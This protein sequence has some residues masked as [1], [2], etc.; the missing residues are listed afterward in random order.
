MF[1]T[2]VLYTGRPNSSM[3]QSLRDL[4]N[5]RADFQSTPHDPH[6]VAGEA[7]LL[8]H[9]VPR[10]SDLSPLGLLWSELEGRPKQPLSSNVLSVNE[11]RNPKPTTPKDIPPVNMRQ[12][13]LSRMNEVSSVRDEWPANFGRLDNMNDANISGRIHQVEAEHHLNFDGHLLLQQIRREQQQQRQ[14]QLMAHNN[15]EFSG[16]FPGQVFDP[17][18][19]HRQPMNQQIPDVEHLLRIQFEL[20]QQQQRQLQQEQHQR[21]LQQQRQAQLLQRQQQQ[22]Q[23]Q[24]QQMILEQLLQQQLQG[25]NFGPTSMVDQVLLR[26]HVLNELH[27]QPHHLQRQHDAAIEQLIQAKFGH[28]LHREHHNDMLDVLSRSNQRQMLPLEQ[29]LLLGLQHEQQLKSQQLANALRQHSGQEEERHLSGVWPMDAAAQFIRSGTSPNQIHSRFDL[30]E[31]LQRSSSFDHH[32]H[33]DRSLSLHE[34]LHMG[35]Q[36]IRSLERTGSLPGGGPGPNPDVINALTR[37]HGLS[38]LET[39]GDVYPLVQM[40][41]LPSGVHPQ[42]LRHQDQLPGSHIGRLERHWSDANGQLQNSLMESSHINQLQIE[43]EKERRNVEMNLSVDNPHAWGALMNKDRNTEQD[44]TDMIHKKLVLQSQQS[45]GFPDVSV[46][47][48]F[49]R[50]DHFVQ[51]VVESPLRSVDMSFEESLSERSLYAKSGQLAQ[52]GSSNLGTLPNS[53]ENTGKFNLRSGSGSMLEQKH[54]LGIDDVQSDFLET[55]GGRTSANQLVGSVNELTRGK[56]QG[57][58][59]SLAGDDPN[60][61][62]EGVSKWYSSKLVDVLLHYLLS[63]SRKFT[64]LPIPPNYRY[65][66]FFACYSVYSDYLTIGHCIIL[67]CL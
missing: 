8:Q 26:E 39:H 22:Q 23:Q 3:G 4:E 41:M 46:P 36:G 57:S 32:E 63:F 40:P 43:A 64:D 29:Q 14:E 27:Q 37:H 60:L 51:P 12:G 54:F 21:Q 17:L 6:S 52:E 65:N 38:Q 10:D 49:R 31:N 34:Q 13:P 62:D 7:N 44:L 19:Q 47:A 53:I 61:A 56:R 58:S 67:T 16:A 35:G 25:S 18:N 48:S 55:T 1:M 50:K 24:Q 11:R 66:I 59:A 28:G 9:N 42:Q 15:L 30:L 5:D 20:E 2:E 45:R 33:L